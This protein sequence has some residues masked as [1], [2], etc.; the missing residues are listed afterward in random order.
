[1]AADQGVNEA[2]QSPRSTASPSISMMVGRP[3]PNCQ[4]YVRNIPRHFGVGTITF[5]VES[6]QHASVAAGWF[7]SSKASDV[8]DA[9][10][11][12]T[13]YVQATSEELEA[14][15]G[16][17]RDKRASVINAKLRER[18]KFLP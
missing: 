13:S 5:D 11:T 1:M 14:V 12:A 15:F 6:G 7:S 10:V 4:P 18:A 8:K 9:F 2:P 17:D 16:M 3:L